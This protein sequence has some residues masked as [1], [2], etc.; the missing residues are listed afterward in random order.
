MPLAIKT[1]NIVQATEQY[2]VQQC[3]CTVVKPHGLSATIAEHFP[4]ACPYARRRQLTPTRNLAVLEDRPAPGTIAVLGQRPVISLFGQFE[5]GRS[6]AFN[7]GLGVSDSPADR[8]EYFKAGLA[9]IAKLNPKSLAI[10]YRIGCGLAGGNW[11]T[12][13]AILED[14]A[15][16]MPN[17]KIML[18]T[19]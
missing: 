1:C 12:Y 6:G 19:I 17:T 5:M 16:N 2:I 7:R 9:E 10:P 11:P 18:Y 14:F 4:D 8:V 15:A 13:R 3:N